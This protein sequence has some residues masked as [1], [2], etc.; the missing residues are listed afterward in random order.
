[1]HNID[2]EIVERFV[3]AMEGIA[4]SL[5]AP[6]QAK[7]FISASEGPHII[8]PTLGDGL[9]ELAGAVAYG[10]S[11]LGT[12]DAATPMGALE[13]LGVAITDAADTIALALSET[14]ES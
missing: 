12:A 13:A 9:L 11:Q 6:S 4:H 10:L 1:M 7:E 3:V 5:S 14:R 2:P 8:T